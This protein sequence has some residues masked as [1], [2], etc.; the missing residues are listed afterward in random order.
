M[1]R[2]WTSRA[3][4]RAISSGERP[5]GTCGGAHRERRRAQRGSARRS[6]WPAGGDRRPRSRG[7]LLHRFRLPDGV[8][9]SPDA[10]WVR[11]DR[12]DMLAPAERRG[13][14]PPVPACCVRDPVGRPRA[15]RPP[16]ESATLPCPRGPAWRAR[17]PGE[18]DRRGLSPRAGG[19]GVRRSAPGCPGSG[20]ARGSSWTSPPFSESR[21]R[22][23]LPGRA[24][25]AFVGFRSVRALDRR[26]CGSGVDTRERPYYNA[27]NSP[28]PPALR[29]SWRAS[30][31]WGCWTMSPRC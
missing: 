7:R 25:G 19:T 3:A 6:A 11:R 9:A 17:G 12:G 29:A 8:L 18:P 23:G 15:P 2:F 27:R 28:G 24:A 26:L 4:P 1:R 30:A 22:S 21:G 14:A 13:F 10:S 31:E 5:R 16:G 20:A